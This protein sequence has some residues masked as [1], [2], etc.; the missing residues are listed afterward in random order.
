MR[1][2]LDIGRA[3][4]RHPTGLQPISDR[5]LREPRL[6][7]VAGKH[8]RLRLNPLRKSRLQRRRYARM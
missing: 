3:C 2:G 6:A 5:L 7:K 4:G 1:G 8:L